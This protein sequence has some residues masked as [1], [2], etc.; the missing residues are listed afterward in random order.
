MFKFIKEVISDAWKEVLGVVIVVS[1][2]CTI[3]IVPIYYYQSKEAKTLFNQAGYDFFTG[4]I[5]AIDYIDYGI[6]HKYGTDTICKGFVDNVES[7][8]LTNDV[9]RH[10]DVYKKIRELAAT[11]YCQLKDIK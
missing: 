1:V 6:T 2:I 3:V 4:K 5:T 7:F 11:G 9:S 8:I 10:D